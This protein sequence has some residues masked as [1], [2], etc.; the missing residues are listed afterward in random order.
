M[1]DYKTILRELN[2]LDAIKRVQSY[3]SSPDFS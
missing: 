3:Q 2:K 1:I